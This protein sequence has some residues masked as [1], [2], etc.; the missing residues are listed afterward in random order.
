MIRHL[1]MQ[2]YEPILSVVDA[3]YSVALDINAETYKFLFESNEL[4][5]GRS[6]SCVIEV[7]C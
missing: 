6:L 2:G 5:D 7:R 4:A 3:R 1:L